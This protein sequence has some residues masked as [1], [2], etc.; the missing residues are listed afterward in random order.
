MTDLVCRLVDWA[1]ERPRNAVMVYTIYWVLLFIV[2]YLL[3]SYTSF[4]PFL[5]WLFY[6]DR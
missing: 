3:A 6:G 4:G 2:F 5:D 1:L